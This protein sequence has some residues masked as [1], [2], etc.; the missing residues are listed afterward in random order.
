MST[1]NRNY[2]YGFKES[3][4]F[5]SLA[6]QNKIQYKETRKS[7]IK[8]TELGAFLGEEY[9][10]P[11]TDLAWLN[12]QTQCEDDDTATSGSTTTSGSTSGDTSSSSGD[13]T[14]GE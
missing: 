8:R 7:D 9:N 2:D 14:V 1:L 10:C 3:E 13:T 5:V 6:K 4:T 11:I 12:L